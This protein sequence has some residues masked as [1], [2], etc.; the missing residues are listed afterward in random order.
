MSSSKNYQHLDTLKENTH[1]NISNCPNENGKGGV[2]TLILGIL[3]EEGGHKKGR[4]ALEREAKK[5]EG[6]RE[7]ETR[8]Y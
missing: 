7:K 8:G 5:D 6:V 4:R 2:L 1:C 3:K